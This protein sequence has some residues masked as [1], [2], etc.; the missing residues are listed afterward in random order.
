MAN[1][2]LWINDTPDGRIGDHGHTYIEGKRHVIAVS[3]VA[4]DGT[5]IRVNFDPKTAR[6][7]STLDI[8]EARRRDGLPVGRPGR[9]GP[10]EVEF[11]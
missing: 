6:V 8:T 1:A 10:A 4:E 3:F 11:A 2:A 5:A 7:T 9:D